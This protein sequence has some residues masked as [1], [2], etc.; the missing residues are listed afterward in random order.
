M[1]PQDWRVLATAP[2]RPP[3]AVPRLRARLRSSPEDFQVDEICGFVPAARG[4]H[5]LLRVRKREANTA[6]V[7][8]ELARRARVR[9]FDVGFAGM[10]DRHAV[11]TQWFSVP[12]RGLTLADWAGHAGEGYQVLEAYAHTRKLPRGALAGN[13]FRI[14]LR[15]VDARDEPTRAAIATAVAQLGVRGVPNYF[16]PQRFGRELGNLAALL[17]PGPAA[18]PRESGF[19]L[20]AARSLVFN[21][22]L[23]E[24]VRRGDWNRLLDGELANLDGSNSVFAVDAADAQ[25]ATR[26]Q[27][28]DI[29]PSGPLWGAGGPRPAGEIAALEQRIAAGLPAALAAIERARVEGARRALRL[30]VRDLEFR[31]L[32]EP[33]ACMLCFTLRSGAFATTV[34]GELF[35][36]GEDPGEAD[37]A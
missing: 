1:I 12:G 2:P 33:D 35:D 29:H 6:W 16:G 13:R 21:A 34:L 31:W 7:A 8:R 19:V 11:T 27:Q 32:A 22:V 36:T 14:V 37:D 18:A 17:A 30:A 26:L 15:G 24:R 10:K 25:L 9:P 23:A 4:E 28:L 3:G 5:F 20:S